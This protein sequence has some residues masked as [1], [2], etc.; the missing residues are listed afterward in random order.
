MTAVSIDP[1]SIEVTGTGIRLI[2]GRCAACGE[3]GFPRQDSCRRCGADGLAA[4]TLADRGVLWSWTVQ[5]YQPPD[6]PYLPQP[7]EFEPF[8]LG[9]VELPGEVIVETRLTDTTGLRIGMPM[10]LTGLEVPT[11]DGGR[12][13]TFAFTPDEGQAR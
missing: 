9:Y 6:P 12:A 5:R 3:I 13:T 1:D 7:G 4:V 8:G 10:R 11:R 2:G